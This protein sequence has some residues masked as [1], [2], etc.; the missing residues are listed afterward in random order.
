VA[1][2]ALALWALFGIVAVGVRVLLHLRRTGTTGV[3]GVSG[4]PGSTEWFAGVS[5]VVATVLG[6]AAPVL[7]LA[8]VVE[9]IA[10]LD[11]GAAHVIGAAL[12]AIGLA[13]LV[14][15][16]AAMGRSWRIGVDESESTALVTGGPFEVV[17]NPIFTT[18][19]VMWIG[20]TLL[21]PS[22]VSLVSL[23]LLVGGLELHTRLVE[24]PYLL[25]THGEVYAA[26]AGR[27]G[28]FVPGVGTLGAR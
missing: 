9:P 6:A 12:F 10:A 15:A 13:V 16:Q 23:A 5:F 25:R 21:V 1:E 24:E 20:L 8:G 26:Y 17:R 11:G 2:L 28:R 27:V 22:V 3:R 19:I 14:W 4:R 7:A 18:M